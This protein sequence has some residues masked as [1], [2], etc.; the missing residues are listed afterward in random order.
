[1]NSTLD[2][3]YT[4]VCYG[5]LLFCVIFCK[6]IEIR[7]YDK[8]YTTKL[9]SNFFLIET[10][11]AYSSNNKNWRIRIRVIKVLT[12][13]Y[14]RVVGLLKDFFKIVLRGTT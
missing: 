5:S 4:S 14:Q 3:S 1:M 8:L 9:T 11:F 12:Y 13:N 10:I 2:P 7:N 6:F